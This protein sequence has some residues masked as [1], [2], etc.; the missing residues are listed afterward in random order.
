L[1]EVW[2]ESALA[3]P[4]EAPR[5]W[6]NILTREKIN[7]PAE[8]KKELRLASVFQQFPVALLASEGTTKKRSPS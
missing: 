7:I 3:L 6:R 2:E 5:R 4:E 1:S 8:A